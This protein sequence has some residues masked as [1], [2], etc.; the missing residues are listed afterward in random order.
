MSKPPLSVC[1]VSGAEARRIGRALASVAPWVSEIVVVL[2]ADVTDGTDK[3]VAAHG[4]KVFREPWRGFIAQKDS[5]TAKCSQPWVLNLDADEEVSPA[6]RDESLRM[7]N[8]PV[9]RCAAYEFP[10]CTRYCGRWIRH[11][12]WY[13]D[14][15]RRLWRRDQARWAGE[16]PHAQ[17]AVSGPVGRL[18]SDLWHYSFQSIEHHVS[19]VVPYQR[20]AARR[21][22]ATGRPGRVI[23]LVLRHG[24]RFLRGYLLRRGFLDGWQGYYIARLNAFATLPVTR[25]SWRLAP[26]RQTGDRNRCSRH[27][28]NRRH[29]ARG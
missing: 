13:P 20:E 12:D 29:E 23:E 16:E 21:R 15:V 17:L 14:R 19:K 11:G 22:L 9:P 26:R 25:C 2:N 18:R 1:M 7:L 6:L 24:W 10:H 4:G 27:P 8:G 5:V 28:A 3:I